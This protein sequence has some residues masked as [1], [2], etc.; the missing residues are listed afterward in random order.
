[1]PRYSV[2]CEQEL[3]ERIEELAVEYELSE[4][5]VIEQLVGIGLD[6]LE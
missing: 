6:E 2:V 4:G 3:A 5:E 1:M